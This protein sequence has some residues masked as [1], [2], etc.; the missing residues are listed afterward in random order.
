M[1][2]VRFGS[3]ILTAL[4]LALVLGGGRARTAAQSS[5]PL[6]DDPAAFLKLVDEQLLL[7]GTAAN[8]AG[9]VQ[10]TYITQDT[11]IMGAQANEALVNAATAFAKHAAKFQNAQV[12]PAERRQLDVARFQRRPVADMTPPAI[13]GLQVLQIMSRS[14]GRQ[15]RRV[16]FVREAHQHA[17]RRHL[18]SRNSHPLKDAIAPRFQIVR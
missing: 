18:V 14:V 15:I 17:C 11:E 5:P 4:V 13:R 10:N 1:R 16:L 12:A 9:W 7:L 6:P 3:A 2:S 8:R